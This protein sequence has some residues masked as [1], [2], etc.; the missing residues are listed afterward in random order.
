MNIPLW[1]RFFLYLSGTDLKTIS[2]CSSD[3]ITRYSILGT[4]LL[5]PSIIGFCSAYYALSL[6]FD[7]QRYTPYVA[8]LWS[9]SIL[10]IDRC[11]IAQNPEVIDANNGQ[12]NSKKRYWVPLSR[13][14]LS[15]V[16]GVVVAEPLL[17]GIFH[18]VISTQITEEI[19]IE[20]NANA[21]PI[22]LRIQASK[23]RID[24]AATAWKV[25]L[26]STTKEIG[27]TSSS[28]RSGR[29]DIAIRKEK[30]EA[31]YESEYKKIEAIEGHHIKSDSLEIVALKKDIDRNKAK[32]LLGQINALNKVSVN[33]L[34]LSISIWLLRLMFIVIELIPLILK[35]SLKKRSD[36]Y[37][38][39]CHNNNLE[40]IE[41]N[42][43]K[44]YQI[45]RRRMIYAADEENKILEKFLKDRNM[46][47]AAANF[48]FY[49]RM[50]KYST[51]YYKKTKL[52]VE[53][54]IE[55]D[56]LRVQLISSMI[57][58]FEEFI[59]ELKNIYSTKY[60]VE[61]ED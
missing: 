56:I 58:A 2:Y 17:V 51:S 19:R 4:L 15:V 40:A 60:S 29:G 13:I 57:A 5:I 12:K 10:T 34:A 46:E 6:V 14:A 38:V 7:N 18:D 24:S 36:A 1:R 3:L 28:K 8:L 30:E 35:S 54:I 39:I 16:L 31:F 22:E 44:E 27:G 11:I 25:K 47:R 26:D 23:K 43:D 59:T 37:V 45:N 50:V 21:E 55:N 61:D 48:K 53:N 52:K 33:N 41:F 32:G 9:F 49:F 20:G 42:K